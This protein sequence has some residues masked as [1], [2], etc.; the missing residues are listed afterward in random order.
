MLSQRAA[1]EF[2]RGWIK[3]WNDHDLEKI[4]VHY[5]DQVEFTSPTAVKL[6]GA[7]SGTVIGRESLRPYFSA[8]LQRFPQLNFKLDRVL[9][10]VGSVVL[11]YRSVNNLQ[12]AELMEF[13]AFGRVARVLGHYTTA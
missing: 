10:G 2:A 7:S 9:T 4:L 5:G 8:A 1:E 12:A 3:A 11:Y 13:D 6:A